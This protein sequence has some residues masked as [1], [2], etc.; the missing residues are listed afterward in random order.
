MNQRNCCLGP[1]SNKYD[2]FKKEKLIRII[3]NEKVNKTASSHIF[4][5]TT[6]KKKKPLQVKPAYTGIAQ[7][8]CY[9]LGNFASISKELGYSSP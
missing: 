2:L 3:P 9:S 7:F 5:T 4:K 8:L 6:T 1:N